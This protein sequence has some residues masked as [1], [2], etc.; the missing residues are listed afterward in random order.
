[1]LVKAVNQSGDETFPA[2]R[3]ETFD[4]A[5]RTLLREHNSDHRLARHESFDIETVMEAAGRLCAVQLL[6]GTQGYALP[7]AEGA[8]DF[9]PPVT[10]P[11]SSAKACLSAGR[12]P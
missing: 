1:M 11:A 8:P 9:S 6:A 4:L 12:C 10:F 7:G 2:S 3:T 5:C